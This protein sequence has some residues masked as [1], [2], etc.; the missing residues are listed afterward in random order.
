MKTLSAYTI[1]WAVITACKGKNTKRDLNIMHRAGL[2][3]SGSHF[4]GNPFMC[5]FATKESAIE[6][7]SKISGLYKPYNV[8]LI[9]DKQFGMSSFNGDITAVATTKQLKESFKIN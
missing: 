1:T 7:I 9:T 2:L 4:Q 3:I 5:H 8:I 6:K